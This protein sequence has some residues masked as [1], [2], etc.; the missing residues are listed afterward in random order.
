MIE[1]SDGV[2][3]KSVVAADGSISVSAG[4]SPGGDERWSRRPTV[5]ATT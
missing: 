1:E 4:G 2:E 5:Q 3:L